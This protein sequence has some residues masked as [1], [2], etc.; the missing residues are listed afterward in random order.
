MALANIFTEDLTS[1][2]TIYYVVLLAIN[3]VLFILSM[4]TLNKHPEITLPLNYVFMFAL[5]W[6]GMRITVLHSDMPAVV[7]VAILLVAPFFFI[8]RPIRQILL[9]VTVTVILI[10]L[11]H[12]YKAPNVARMDLWNGIAICISTVGIEIIQMKDKFQNFANVNRVLYLSMTDVLTNA[13]NRN[14]YEGRLKS[15]E[16][17]KLSD[18]TV[19][20]VDVNGLHEVNNTQGHAAGDKMLK[21][22]ASRMIDRFGDENTFRVGGDEFVAVLENVPYE[23]A[24]KQMDTAIEELEALNYHISVGVKRGSEEHA[25]LPELVKDAEQEMYAMK[26]EFYRTRGI[27]RRKARRD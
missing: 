5:Y 4:T 22:V 27:D 26:A 13:R 11:S 8:D 12:I 23:K 21:A 20:Y 2:N 17:R 1:S 9:T 25:S 3:A 15:L 16:G 24:R 6:F 7:A 14:T 10:V 19:V 18:L